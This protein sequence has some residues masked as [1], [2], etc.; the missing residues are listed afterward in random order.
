MGAIVGFVVGVWNFVVSVAPAVMHVACQLTQ[1][2]SDVV[3]L[4]GGS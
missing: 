4:G 2:A 3:K 1:G